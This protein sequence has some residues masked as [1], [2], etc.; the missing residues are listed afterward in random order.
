MLEKNDR[1]KIIFFTSNFSLFKNV[2]AAYG[3]KLPG[4]EPFAISNKESQFPDYN[5]LEINGAKPV[6][7]RLCRTEKREKERI[8]EKRGSQE[9]LPL[10]D[11][12]EDTGGRGGSARI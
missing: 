6:S 12:Y 5:R 11:G 4:R 3:Q 8:L 9:R 1:R 10:D 7:V 2:Y